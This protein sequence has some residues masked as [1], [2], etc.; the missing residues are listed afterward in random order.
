[1]IVNELLQKENMSR[2]RL[3]KE[4]GV[5]MTTITDICSGK[6]ELDKCAAGTIYKIAK[7]LGVSVDFLLENNKER[8][9]DYRCSFETFK[10]NTCHHVKDLGDI[11][12]IIETLETDEIRKLYNRQW[13]REALYLLAMVDYL[14]RLNSLPICTN[15]NDLRCKKLE[16]PYFPASVAVSYAATGDERIKNEAVANAI[17]EFLRFNIVESEVRNVC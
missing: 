15:Y 14:S 6:A 13:Y 8:S 12:F 4:S 10:S 5:A 1:M 3:S 17:P 11:D 9:A 2:Y 7:V 16:K